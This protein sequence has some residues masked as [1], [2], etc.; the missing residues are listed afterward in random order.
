MGLQYG[1]PLEEFVDG[2]TFTRFEPW[3]SVDHPNIKF[4][5]SVI[6]YVFRV[7]GYEYLGRTDFLQVKPEDLHSD[8]DLP[9]PAAD[10]PKEEGVHE[11][12]ATET[13]PPKNDSQGGNG[14]TAAKGA[15]PPPKTAGIPPALTSGNGGG[16]RAFSAE[17]AQPKRQPQTLVLD[18]Q[19]SQMMGDAPFCDVCGH[20]TIRN[21]SCY[22]CLN[23]GHSMGCS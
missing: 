20:I 1:V 22:K 18:D 15:S 5:T 19:L 3:G 6:D 12:G 11:S 10:S 4:A 16:S 17:S 14:Q 23:C 9:H 7:L 21:G 2:F 8:T 13:L